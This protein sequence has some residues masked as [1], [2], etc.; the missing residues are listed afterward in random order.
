MTYVNVCVIKTEES[1]ASKSPRMQG[2][3]NQSNRFG[4]QAADK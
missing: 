1:M 3:V 4:N 2:D